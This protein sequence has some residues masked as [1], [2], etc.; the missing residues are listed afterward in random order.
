MSK[1][2]VSVFCGIRLATLFFFDFLNQHFTSASTTD[3]FH[4]Y[5]PVIGD[6]INYGFEK[7]NLMKNNYMYATHMY[8]SIYCRFTYI[9]H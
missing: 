9:T 6:G 2:E 8:I 4:T 7:S 5:R 1:N 3:F